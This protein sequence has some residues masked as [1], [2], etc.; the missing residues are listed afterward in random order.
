[1]TMPFTDWGEA[2]ATQVQWVLWR[3]PLSL[4]HAVA[5]GRVTAV[6]FCVVAKDTR[7]QRAHDCA[8]LDL[9]G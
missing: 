5:T 8:S 2:S 6:K 4:I 3:V 9:R 1:M 7:G